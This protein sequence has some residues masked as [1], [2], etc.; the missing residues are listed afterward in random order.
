MFGH[1]EKWLDAGLYLEYFKPKAALNQPAAFEFK[2][3]LE[4]QSRQLVNTANLILTKEV[5]RNAVTHT[6]AGYAWRSKWRWSRQ[7]EPAIELYGSLGPVHNTSSLS[8]QTHQLGVV[9]LGKLPGDLSYEVG[10]LFGLTSATER[11][12]FKFVIAYE[13]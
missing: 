6:I 4:K 13:L 2:L 5:G 12:M 3:L 7:M 8:G 11:G 9:M 1:G 10:Y